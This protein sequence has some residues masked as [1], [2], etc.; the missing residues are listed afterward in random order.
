VAGS[1]GGAAR[2]AARAQLSRL[3]SALEVWRLEHGEYPRRLADLVEGGLLAARDLRQPFSEDYYYRRRAEGG[4]I[5]L[6]RLP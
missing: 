2:F 4:F 5:L 3:E 1:G 6:P